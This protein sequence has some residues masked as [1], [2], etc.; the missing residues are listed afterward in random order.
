MWNE[1]FAGEGYHYGTEPT[2]FLTRHAG[3]LDPG[4]SVLSVAEG[5][6]RNAVWLAGQG[7]QVTALE[8]APNAIAKAR[9]LAQERGVSVHFQQA[10]IFD[11]DWPADSF[12]AVLACFIQFA[13]PP[14]RTLIFQ[15]LARAIKPGGLLMLHGYAPRQVDNGTGGPPCADFMYTTELLRAA[16]AGFSFLTLED[17]DAVIEEGVGHSGKSALID[18]IAR[19]PL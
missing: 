12:D 7:M 16:F 19:K 11:F 9:K 4:M 17:Y 5:E 6:G 13:P 14:E 8:Y 18:C 3:V 2:A 15:G 10:D 1:I